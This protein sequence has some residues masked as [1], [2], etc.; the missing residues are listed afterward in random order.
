MS[1]EISSMP[2]PGAGPF[3]PTHHKMGPSFETRST[4]DTS[5]QSKIS[6]ASRFK[7]LVRVSAG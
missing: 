3:S 7:D 6:M 5:A 4:F 2:S 1:I